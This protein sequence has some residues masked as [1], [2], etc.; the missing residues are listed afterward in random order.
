MPKV[1]I[2]PAPLAGLDGAFLHLLRDAGFELTY[3]AK[4]AQMTEDEIL[5]TLNGVV[6]SMA[7][8]AP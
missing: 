3:P 2:A 6:A 7:S 5:A 8:M 1:L 4:A